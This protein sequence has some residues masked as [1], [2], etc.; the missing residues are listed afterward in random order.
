MTFDY[1]SMQTLATGLLGQFKQGSMI[2]EKSVK[3]AG[4][5]YAPGAPIK[6]YT[7]LSAVGKG[8]AEYFKR[9]GLADASEMKITTA[10]VA[11]IEPTIA[12]DW[13]IIGGTLAAG[14]VTGGIR[15]K[16][17]DWNPV[18]NRNA[19]IVWKFTVKKG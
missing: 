14:V 10:V 7:E 8:V 9:A 2:L 11:G 16:V 1:G 5:A 6:S 13:I 18:P 4:P 19:P 12:E 3:G 15:M 17:I